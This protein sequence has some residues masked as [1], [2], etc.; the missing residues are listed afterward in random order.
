[1]HSASA[2]ARV[3][4]CF[5]WV[6]CT[7]MLESYQADSDVLITGNAGGTIAPNID[8]TKFYYRY[9][10]QE[11]PA[12]F[13]ASFR[14]SV[15]KLSVS[16]FPAWAYKG[17]ENL[18]WTYPFF[19]AVSIRPFEKTMVSQCRFGSEEADAYDGRAMKASLVCVLHL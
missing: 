3:M 8:A 13:F 18:W 16:S 19:L 6:K 2:H 10:N 1:M 17:F 5:F 11:S 12:A 7:G 14:R 4:N 15:W 9:P